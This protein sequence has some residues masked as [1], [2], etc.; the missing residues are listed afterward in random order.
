MTS[1]PV[2]IDGRRADAMPPLYRTDPLAKVVAGRLARG[3]WARSLKDEMA[4][5]ARRQRSL[6]YRPVGREKRGPGA[7]PSDIL[8]S[9]EILSQPVHS[10]LISRISRCEGGAN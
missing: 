8:A 2:D 6:I 3:E 1:R 5:S 9:R 10:M 4:G 7:V